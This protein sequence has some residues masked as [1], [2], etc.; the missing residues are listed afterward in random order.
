MAFSALC[1]HA[2]YP[3][4]WQFCYLIVAVSKCIVIK[5]N[6]ETV[7]ELIVFEEIMQLLLGTKFF[8]GLINEIL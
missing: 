1:K 5:S 6:R 4:P 7:L 3:L 8:H 2:M